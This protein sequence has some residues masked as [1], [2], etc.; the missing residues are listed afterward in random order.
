MLLAWSDF[1]LLGRAPL[2]GAGA[3]GEAGLARA[4]DIL[5]G[6]LDT[7]LGQLGCPNVSDLRNLERGH[8]NWSRIS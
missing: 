5:Q 1:T 4:L 8:R 2:Y 3:G 6:E 7:A